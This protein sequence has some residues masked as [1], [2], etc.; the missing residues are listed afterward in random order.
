M[1]WVEYFFLVKLCNDFIYLY[2]K[3]KNLIEI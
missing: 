3:N 1:D 2:N